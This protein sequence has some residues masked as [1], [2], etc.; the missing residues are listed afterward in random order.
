MR[1]AGRES[2]LGVPGLREA[3]RDEGARLDE[4]L[5]GTCS[6]GRPRN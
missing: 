5:A 1:Q 3:S 2:A 4:E 6:P